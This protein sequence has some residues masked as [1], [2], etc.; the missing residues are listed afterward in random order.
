MLVRGT[1]RTPRLPD[2]KIANFSPLA[3]RERDVLIS[4]GQR[5]CLVAKSSPLHLSMVIWQALRMPRRGTPLDD[6]IG[7]DSVIDE[8]RFFP[9][10]I[11]NFL[12]TV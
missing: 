11:P 3:A 1:V 4:S 12:D 8:P 10:D 2:F 9:N 5:S 6:D 7:L